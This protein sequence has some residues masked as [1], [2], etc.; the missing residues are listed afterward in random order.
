L[1]NLS[2][3]TFIVCPKFESKKRVYRIPRLRK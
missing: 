1:L 3:A 2:A